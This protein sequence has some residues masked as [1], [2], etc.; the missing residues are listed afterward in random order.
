MT[1][2][3]APASDTGAKA[4]ETAQAIPAPAPAAKPETIPYERFQQ[5]NTAK[6][7]AEDAL[8]AIVDGMVNE[9][10]EGMRELVPNLPPAEK[11]AWIRT[12]K[13]KGLFA[14]PAPSSSPD[15]KRPV[16]KP[17]EQDL[18]AMTP[19]QMMRLGYGGKG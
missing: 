18:S 11:A 4:E 2:D 13:E 12:A 17:S 9:L 15:P 7:A 19:L 5:V 16:N 14:V 3:T 1:I 6:K 8:T 10:P